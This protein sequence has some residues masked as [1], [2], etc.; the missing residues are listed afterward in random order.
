M[1]KKLLVFSVLTVFMLIAI[2]FASAINTNTAKSFEKKESPLYDIRTRRAIR[3]KIGNIITRFVGE[4]MFFLPFQWTI[5]IK[6]ISKESDAWPTG[7]T[8]PSCRTYCGSCRPYP[9]NN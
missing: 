2:S 7:F 3:E 4:Q 1:N 6:H 9:E 5:F 8:Y